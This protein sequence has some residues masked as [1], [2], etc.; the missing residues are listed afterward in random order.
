MRI[1]MREFQASN[2]RSFQ[3]SV[4]GHDH[5]AERNAENAA[6][7]FFGRLAEIDIGIFV[8]AE[9][10]FLMIN[11]LAYDV[12]NE[13]SPTEY[14]REK[15]MCELTL[16]VGKG[17]SVGYPIPPGPITT[18]F[19]SEDEEDADFGLWIHNVLS[20]RERRKIIAEQWKAGIP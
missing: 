6:I 16:H 14:R 4:A 17:A 18:V 13:F 2:R 19:Y 11:K 15:T 20:S 8:M 1:T 3:C 7:G 10:I 5:V 9:H 12:T